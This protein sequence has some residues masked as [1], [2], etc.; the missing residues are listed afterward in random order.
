[1]RSRQA[2]LAGR[3]ASSELNGARSG[4]RIRARLHYYNFNYPNVI[5]LDGLERSARYSE[6]FR[7]DGHP[8][9]TMGLLMAARMFGQPFPPGTPPGVAVDFGV[10]LMS[11]DDAEARLR[12]DARRLEQLYAAFTR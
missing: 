4:Q 3:R 2:A 5:T 7:S 12:D 10:D 1:V 8:R 6:Y 11:V 9:P